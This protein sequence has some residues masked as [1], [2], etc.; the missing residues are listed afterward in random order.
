[1]VLESQFDENYK[2]RENELSNF[3]SKLEDM[4]NEL[5]DNQFLLAEVKKKNESLMQDNKALAQ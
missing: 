1:V 5:E 2:N 3:K 4:K